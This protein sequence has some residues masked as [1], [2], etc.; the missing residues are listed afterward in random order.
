MS[1]IRGKKPCKLPIT[2]HLAPKP[3]S[4]WIG[5]ALISQMVIHSAKISKKGEKLP[6]S[7]T[8]HKIAEDG[9]ITFTPNY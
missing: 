7:L 1:D 4:L 2:L 8:I 3:V 9:S 6:K 5:E